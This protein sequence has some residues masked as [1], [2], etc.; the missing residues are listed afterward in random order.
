MRNA[1]A[2][3]LRGIKELH[4]VSPKFF[5]LLTVYSIFSAITPY[6]TVFF[7]AQILKELATLRREESLWQWVT[8]AVHCIMDAE[9]WRFF[10]VVQ[11]VT[12]YSSGPGKNKMK[13]G[14]NALPLPEFVKRR[15][16]Q[17]ELSKNLR[18]LKYPVLHSGH[19]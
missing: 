14:I 8:V 18:Q 1:A 5:P 4:K 3:Q 11:R 15:F 2:L 9:H 10:W 6:V 19:Y 17:S 13:P 7:S 16:P 12:A